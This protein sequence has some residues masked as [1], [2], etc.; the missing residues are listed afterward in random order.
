MQYSAFI[1]DQIL[2]L[3]AD[4]WS[5]GRIALIDGMPSRGQFLRWRRDDAKLSARY[6]K[7][8]QDRVAYSFDKLSDIALSLLDPEDDKYK[9][10]LYEVRAGTDIL[11]KLMGNASMIVQGYSAGGDSKKV[12]HVRVEFVTSNEEAP[13]EAL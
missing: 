1:A 13:P 6:E 2:E 11:L 8:I 4:G 7:A 10:H 9:S 5:L 12:P 3:I